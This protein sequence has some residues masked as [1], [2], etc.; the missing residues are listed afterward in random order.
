MRYLGV[1]VAAMLIA[2]AGFFGAIILAS[3]SGEVVVLQTTDADGHPHETRLW[4]VDHAGAE[5]VRTG[6]PEKSWFV[7][8]QANPAV[9]LERAGMTTARVAVVV[10]DPAIS[11]ALMKAFAEKYGEADWI[12]ALSGDAAKRVPVRLD[13]A[14]P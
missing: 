11:G 6:A 9:E 7:R 12:V 5:W 3:E 4:I 1:L 14:R 10:R 13:P 2:I 8:L